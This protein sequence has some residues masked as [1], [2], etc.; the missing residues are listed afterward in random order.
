MCP[1]YSRKSCVCALSLRWGV[2]KRGPGYKNKQATVATLGGVFVLGG[3]CETWTSA[4]GSTLT[5]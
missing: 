2:D 1:E 3:C 4:L 5:T